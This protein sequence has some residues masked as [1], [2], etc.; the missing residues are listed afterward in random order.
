[1]KGLLLSGG[2]DSICLAYWFRK[3]L[4]LAITIDY[5]Q[6]SANAE[7][8]ASKAVCDNLG[9][10]HKLITIDCSQLGR[11][12]MS[13]YESSELSEF[14]EWWP[15]R[16]QLL[17]TLACMAIVG[18]DVTELLIGTVSSDK[19]HKDGTK[20]FIDNIHRLIHQQEGHI[21][22]TAPGVN[23]TSRELVL[24]SGVPKGLLSWA[25]SCHKSNHP[26]GYCNGC[27]KHTTVMSKLG[28][29]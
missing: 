17:I 16:N 9:I 8:I 25:H 21:V 29:Y 13:S 4:K 7:L 2:I 23:F 11:G 5:G 24:H 6:K 18:S 14:S 22:I 3:S 20:E 27:R 19:R 28:L 1:M 12:D 26:C 15:Y 10:I